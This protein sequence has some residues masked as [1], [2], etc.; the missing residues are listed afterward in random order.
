MFSVKIKN[1]YLNDCED[2]E[3]LEF[4]SCHS[5][6]VAVGL[7]GYGMCQMRGASRSTIF[8]KM[9]R[10]GCIIF[11][12]SHVLSQSFVHRLASRSLV[13]VGNLC[14]F[15]CRPLDDQIVRAL[16]LPT[17][18]FEQWCGFEAASCPR[19]QNVERRYKL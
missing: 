5:F 16:L 14:L 2:T 13:P 17:L 7:C 11:T 8:L 4:G 10:V 3:L 19:D 1:I 9:Q 6:G 18:V 12:Q 15:E